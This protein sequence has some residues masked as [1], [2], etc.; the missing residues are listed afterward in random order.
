MIVSCSRGPLQ[1]RQAE[2][3][4]VVEEVVAEEKKES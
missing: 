1:G 2:E 3:G 4:V